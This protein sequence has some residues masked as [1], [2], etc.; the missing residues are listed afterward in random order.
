MPFLLSLRAADVLPEEHLPSMSATVAALISLR[1]TTSILSLHCKIVLVS[2][3]Y[4]VFH[5]IK[6]T[7]YSVIDYLSQGRLATLSCW[8]ALKILRRWY[9]LDEAHQK[10]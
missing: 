9:W 7:I 10:C 5:Y 2:T 4:S 1:Y 8:Y 3:H 6:T